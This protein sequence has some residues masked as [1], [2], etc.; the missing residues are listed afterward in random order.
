MITGLSAV[1]ILLMTDE[2]KVAIIVSSGTLLVAI[3]GLIVSLVNHGTAQDLKAGVQKIEISLDG[4]WTEVKNLIR[5][6][7]HAAGIEEE[8]TSVALAAEAHAAGRAEEKQSVADI[9]QQAE[10]INKDKE[11]L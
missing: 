1:G 7:A 5:K 11:K 8:R 2:I 3:V 10:Q 9:K 6:E 4:H